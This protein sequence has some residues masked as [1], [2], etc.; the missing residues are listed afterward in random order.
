MIE[1]SSRIKKVLI[2]SDQHT[3][4]A[5]GPRFYRGLSATG[6]RISILRLF[7]PKEDFGAAD[8]CLLGSTSFAYAFR[9]W[10][11]PVTRQQMFPSAS[12]N[13]NSIIQLAFPA[14]SA[15]L[16]RRS[17]SSELNEASTVTSVV[18]KRLNLIVVS[19]RMG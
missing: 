2:F 11:V 6:C 17:T 15:S 14:W 3:H 13:S 4:Y 8:S 9:S 12:F 18:A 7:E 1:D 10:K 5:E 19:F 16:L